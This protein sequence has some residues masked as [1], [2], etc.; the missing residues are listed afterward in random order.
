[1]VSGEG[2]LVCGQCQDCRGGRGHLCA[3]TK[4]LGVD[5]DGAFAEFVVI[6]ASNVWKHSQKVAPDVAAIFDPI[7]NAVHT[8][9]AFPVQG[10]SILIT[11]AGPIGLMS[12]V[13]AKGAG[14][15]SVVVSDLSRYRLALAAA[16]GADSTVNISEQ[17]IEE[18]MEPLG[19]DHFDIAVEVS[20]SRDG[21]RDALKSLRNGGGLAALGLPRQLVDVDWSEL[22]RRMITVKG[23]FGRE[24]FDT[25]FRVEE[26]LAGGV[27]FGRIV[28]HRFPARDWKD[29]F[30]TAES[31]EC[32]KV[33]LDWSDL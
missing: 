23:I 16:M 33:V 22:V 30:Q 25:W 20:G 6:P 26:L 2:H 29:A 11:G 14:A 9:S 27:D 21:I 1:M 4:S 12:L 17:A 7:G 32:G 28:T 18:S 3:R 15:K 10:R 19:V 5:V 13:I 31:G 24:M 8:L